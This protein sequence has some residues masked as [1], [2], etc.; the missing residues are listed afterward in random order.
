MINKATI[1]KTLAVLKSVRDCGGLLENEYED[2]AAIL[3]AGANPEID[4][5][6]LVR[7]VSIKTAGK[8]LEFSACKIRN[9]LRD[10]E[11]RKI[12]INT[13]TVRIPLVDIQKYINDRLIPVPVSSEQSLH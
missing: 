1:T 11:M 13:T 7:S 9:M 2:I 6:E 10:G 4:P 12:A 3:R 5:H 8:I